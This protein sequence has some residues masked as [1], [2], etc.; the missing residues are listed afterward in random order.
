MTST[1]PKGI[2]G[3]VASLLEATLYLRAMQK[4]VSVHALLPRWFSI[5][6]IEN[7]KL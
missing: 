5:N 4:L 1:L 2:L 3:L 6:R 7:T